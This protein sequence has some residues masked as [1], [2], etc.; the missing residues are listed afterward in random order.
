[1]SV[2]SQVAVLAA[3]ILLVLVSVAFIPPASASTE[4][5]AWSVGNWW[6]YSITGQTYV[7]VN[8]SSTHLK[9]VVVGTD[10]ISWLGTTYDT[11]HTK[12]WLNTTRGSTTI[13]FPGDAWWRQ[14]DLGLVR[15]RLTGNL[16]ILFTQV[17]LEVTFT[18]APPVTTQWPLTAGANWSATSVV[19]TETIINAGVPSWGNATASSNFS[20]GADETVTVAA[21]TFS[22][23]P[24]T[25]TPS[26]GGGHSTSHH[27]RDAGNTVDSKSYSSNGSQTGS[28]ELTAYSYSPPLLSQII[29]G[30]Q[31]WMWLV[32]LAAVVVIAVVGVLVLR[33]R[34][35]SGRRGMPPMQPGEPGRPPGPPPG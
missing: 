7:P 23:T 32:V 34:R 29:L 9:Y 31:L 10:S 25:E 28:S 1:M 27:A 5:P 12:V 26:S 11:Y 22:A 19:T 17:T 24:V 21:G 33:R 8:G 4:K 3:V 18:W 2:R 14:S 16:T 15:L 30:L 20:V 35:S 13:S 6:D